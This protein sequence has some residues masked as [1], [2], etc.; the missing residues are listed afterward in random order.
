MKSF[1]EILQCEILLQYKQSWKRLFPVNI[2]CSVGYFEWTA[3]Y[4]VNQDE[5]L[6]FY[7]VLWKPIN[8]QTDDLFYFK[9][10]FLAPKSGSM[11]ITSN[12]KTRKPQSLSVSQ[13]VGY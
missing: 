4:L 13:V 5:G 3:G 1:C 8:L 6:N 11:T 2:I 7:L 12:R 9:R 10:D